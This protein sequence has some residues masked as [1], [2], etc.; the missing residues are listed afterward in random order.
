[1]AYVLL[2]GVGWTQRWEIAEGALPAVEDEIGRVGTDATGHV[3]IIDPGTGE[4]ASLVVAWR[5]VAAAVVLGS[6]GAA[7]A[8]DT[9]T[10]G[11]YR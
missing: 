7:A 8:A 1:M 4:P 10:P 5:H 6:D 11:L 9:E 2:Y 3:A